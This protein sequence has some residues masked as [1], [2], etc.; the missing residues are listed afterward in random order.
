MSRFSIAITF[1][2]L[3]AHGIN[4]KELFHSPT[5]M[6]WFE[7]N[8]Y[9]GQFGGRLA[10]IMNHANHVSAVEYYSTLYPDIK[11]LWIGLNDIQEDG[12][13]VW[14]YSDQTIVTYWNEGQP[15]WDASD[16]AIYT[17]DPGN[18][19]GWDDVDCYRPIHAL[20]EKLP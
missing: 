10:R 8:W 20:C 16:C 17:T 11:A 19:I 14:G 2:I 15:S 9:C 7:A 18:S 4:G 12:N 1:L 3:L 13:W 6:D 5:L